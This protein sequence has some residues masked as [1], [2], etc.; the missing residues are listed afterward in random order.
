MYDQWVIV[1]GYLFYLM[2]ALLLSCVFL[3]VSR[4]KKKAS[5]VSTKIVKENFSKEICTLWTILFT[6]SITYIIRAVW[7][8]ISVRQHRQDFRYTL[9]DITLH[10]LYDWIP[11]MLMLMFHF[12]NFR[13]LKI[14]G[15]LRL[16]AI[17]S[18]ANG[19]EQP[20]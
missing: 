13:E 4:M 12:K 10:I 1:Q 15:E 18:N 9:C 11:I 6:F 14:S 7:D 8:Q 20:A 17:G 2:G 19:N 5:L 3:L 16:V